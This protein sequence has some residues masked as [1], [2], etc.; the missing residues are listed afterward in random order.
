MARRPKSSQHPNV[1]EIGDKLFYL[2]MEWVAYPTTPTRVEIQENA[3][4]RGAESYAL[5]IGEN[6]LQVGFCATSIDELPGG[7]ASLAA[8]LADSAVQPWLGTF[9]IEPG[10]WWYIAVRD[11][12]A[13]LLGGDILGNEEQVAAAQDAHSSYADWRYISGDLDDLARMVKE[14]KAGNGK[15]GGKTGARLQSVYTTPGERRRQIIAATAIT[16]AVSAAGAGYWYW[17]DLQEKA[18]LAQ[19]RMRMDSLRRGQIDAAKAAFVSPF[20]FSPAPGRLLV[21]CRQVFASTPISDQGW[22]ADQITCTPKGATIEW[23]RGDGASV[24]HV[25]AD[26]VVDDSGDRATRSIPFALQPAPESDDALVKLDDL[27]LSLLAWAQ[28]GGF[29]FSTKPVPPP[30]VPEGI[31][32]KELPPVIPAIAFTLTTKVSPLEMI[33]DFESYPGL[34]LTS[35]KE[36]PNGWTTE[37]VLYGKR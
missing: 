8:C 29:G 18:Y 19:Q 26:A 13:I 21:A 34:R 32:P 22:T 4:L 23:M 20:Y 27:K 15:M 10:R 25:P 2:G 31:D 12:N 14:A 37:G 24:R 6:A 33:E 16:L 9:E 36:S 1:V 17:T 11:H 35:L 28:E 7:V 3:E 30:S 5:R